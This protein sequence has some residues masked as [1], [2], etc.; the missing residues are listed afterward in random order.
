M[1]KDDAAIRRL[2]AAEPRLRERL[3]RWDE[4]EAMSDEQIHWTQMPPI[5][6]DDPDAPIPIW[7]LGVA[8]AMM[9]DAWAGEWK[10]RAER[11]K[12][13]CRRLRVDCRQLS[14]H[15]DGWVA[16]HARMDAENARLRAAYRRLFVEGIADPEFSGPPAVEY[17]EGDLEKFFGCDP[18]ATKGEW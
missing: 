16:D 5:K 12:A 3:R 7:K 18:D 2:L 10:K 15:I 11:W 13:L 4:G 1:S 6:D 9:A 17:Q 14:D 8:G